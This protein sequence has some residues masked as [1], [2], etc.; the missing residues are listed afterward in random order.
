MIVYAKAPYAYVWGDNN[1]THKQGKVY[2]ETPLTVREQS[3]DWL[4][5]EPLSY[6][7]E[8]DRLVDTDNYPTFWIRKE[9]VVQLHGSPVPL[10]EHW[11]VRFVRWLLGLFGL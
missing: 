7:D 4:I 5:I 6:P 1:A 11:L 9:D 10:K 3:G 8:I 2:P